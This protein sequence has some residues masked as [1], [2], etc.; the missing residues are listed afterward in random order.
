MSVTIDVKSM[1]PEYHQALA[2]L[3]Y[4]RLPKEDPRYKG[5]TECFELFQKRFNKKINTYRHSKDTY[6]AY[7]DTNNRVGWVGTPIISRGQEYQ[8]VYDAYK[9]YDLDQL[10][11]A[12]SQI[13]DIYKGPEYNYMAL[14]LTDA[15]TVHG[16]LGGTRQFTV[17]RIT[18]LSEEL[19]VG[20]IIFIALGGDKGTAEVDWETGFYAIAHVIKPPYDKG[21]EKNKRG[22][23]YFKFDIEIDIVLDSP[24]PRS[25]FLSYPD[26]YDAAYIGLEIHRD[27]S[28]ANS[29]LDDNKA[30]A[31]VRATIDKMPHLKQRF[32]DVFPEDFM[33]R[34]FGSA[35]ILVP[36]NVEYGEDLKAAVDQQ[37]NEKDID[38]EEVVDTSKL[39]PY[40]KEEFLSQVYMDEKD[41]D[42]L[43]SMLETKKNIILQGAPGVGKTFMAKRLAYSLVGYID[44]SRV[45]MIQF[46]QS[47]SYEDF[48]VG[49]RP[50]KEG[51]VLEYGPFYDFCKKAERTPGPHFFIIDEINRGNV[52]KIFGELLM[53]IEHD[54]RN[55]SLELLYTK[56]SFSVPENVYIIGMMNTADRSLALIDYALRRRFAFY[57]V[58]PA[59]DK[60]NFKI[61]IDKTVSPKRVNHLITYVKK[62]NEAIRSDE[63]LG[64]GFE[65][66]HSYFC[67]APE[68]SDAPNQEEALDSWINMTVEYEIIP[69]IKEY[70]F[71]DPDKVTEWSDKLREAK[72][73][74]SND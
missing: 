53:L 50:S 19:T 28:Q 2:C 27:R 70:W 22:T 46:H 48:I 5:R 39:T 66:G 21:Y 23:D 64:A 41:Y 73:D 52:S 8:D 9:D 68:A 35:T 29:S 7:F 65:V 62:L 13:I 34:V 30:V 12:V 54:K 31:I 44:E 69:L 15:T 42:L 37:F 58:V 11:E 17:D 38:E 14:R 49:Y 1:T 6:D 57:D 10:A 56:E 16:I 51:F 60:K 25:G 55:E 20:K 67:N 26:T 74:I 63:S 24:I 72:K 33:K 18:D 47:Y 45:Q 4:A 32:I 3:F 43:V 71:D 36:A 40:G 61:Q 59:F